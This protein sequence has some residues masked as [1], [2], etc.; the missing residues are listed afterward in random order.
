[1]NPIGE[2]EWVFVITWQ[3]TQSHGEYIITLR[4]CASGKFGKLFVRTLACFK[5]IISSALGTSPIQ[6]YAL[7]SGTLLRVLLMVQGMK[8]RLVLI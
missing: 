4:I 6:P 7:S 1:M 8:D 3:R 5:P 2:V